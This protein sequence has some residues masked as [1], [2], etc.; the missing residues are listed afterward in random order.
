MSSK[1]T[2]VRIY[3]SESEIDLNNL[4]A[5]LHDE[6]RVHGVTVFRG[7]G[8]FGKSGKIH[9]ASLIDAAFDLP[10]VVEFYETETRAHTV[11][12]MIQEKFNLSHMIYWNAQGWEASNA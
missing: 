1:F 5:H 3:L 12:S 9:G 8:G 2:V 4:L 6:E 11:M 7:I 10:I